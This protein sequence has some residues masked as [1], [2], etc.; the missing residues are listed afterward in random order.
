MRGGGFVV[1]KTMWSDTAAFWREPPSQPCFGV[2]SL[3]S[4]P[5]SAGG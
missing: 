3:Q 4:L 5:T 1:P 2:I